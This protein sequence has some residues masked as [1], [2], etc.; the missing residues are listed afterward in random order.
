MLISQNG[1]EKPKDSRE[2]IVILEKNKILSK[3]VSLQIQD[4]ISFRNLLVHRYG[5]VN[6]KQEY[7]NIAENHKDVLDFVKEVKLFIKKNYSH[8]TI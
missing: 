2:A 3:K 8:P 6:E 1:F 5:K 7:E 4:F